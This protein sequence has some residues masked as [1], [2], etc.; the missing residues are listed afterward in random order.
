MLNERVSIETFISQYRYQSQ[1]YLARASFVKK[2]QSE[3]RLENEVLIVHVMAIYASTPPGR[4]AGDV[5]PSMFWF[6]GTSMGMS[7]PIFGVAM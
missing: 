1:I 6:V 5:S 4:D 7:P 2:T 3:A